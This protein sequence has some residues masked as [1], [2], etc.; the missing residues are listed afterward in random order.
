[1][2]LGHHTITWGGVVGHPSGV[3]S[4]KDLHY[5]SN[6]SVLDA[7]RDIGAAGYAGVEVFDGN[8]AAL[9]D[10]PEPFLRAMETAGVE[11]VSVYTGANFIYADVLPDEM[12]KVRAACELAARFGAGRLVVGGGARRAAGVQEEDHDR[13]AAALDRVTDLA[14]DHGLDASYHPHL[15][16]IVE[17]PDELDRL[18]ERTRIGFCPDTAH[19]AAG[20]G[21]PA[22]LIRRY[23]ERLQHVHLKDV[24]L[25]TQTFLPLGL[26]DLDLRDIVRAIREAE[27]DSWLVVELDSTPGDPLDAARTSYEHLV[28]LLDL[29]A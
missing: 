15:G 19:L 20:G 11:L 3:T 29:P 9:A 8:L 22:E 17:S 28:E 23:P 27:Y 7:V 18:M 1:M 12:A 14:A 4:A 13:L 2:R 21:D 24:D 10:R 26:G 16:T 25:A 5:L 6:G